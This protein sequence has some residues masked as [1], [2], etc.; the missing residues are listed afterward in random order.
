MGCFDCETKS[1]VKRRAYDT[2]NGRI[3]ETM[4]ADV[5]GRLTSMLSITD[6]TRISPSGRMSVIC[7][8]NTDTIRLP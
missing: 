6:M 5:S 4:E 8:D 7:S 3:G 1:I 2:T